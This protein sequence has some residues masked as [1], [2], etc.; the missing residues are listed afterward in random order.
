MVLGGCG[1]DSADLPTERDAVKVVETFYEQISEAKLRGG[2]L[3]IHEA[4]KLI[5]SERS[6]LSDARFAQTVEKYPPGFRAEVISSKIDGRH[7]EVTIEYQVASM[8][9]KPYAVRTVIPLAVDKAG[10][11]WKIDFTGETDDQ[12]PAAAKK[13]ML[14]EGAKK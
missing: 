5:D 7:A 14:S 13:T 8:F 10:Q 4:Y 11:T 12:D 9:G 1:E 3:H 6:H 2:T